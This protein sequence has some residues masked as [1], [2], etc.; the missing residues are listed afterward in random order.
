MTN[1]T[2]LFFLIPL[3]FLTR[4]E[5]RLQ[6]PSFSQTPWWVRRVGRGFS[7]RRPA[8][9][10]WGRKSGLWPGRLLCTASRLKGRN[11]G[12]E[13]Q[14]VQES[15]STFDTNKCAGERDGFD[16]KRSRTLTVSDLESIPEQCGG[17]GRVRL[18]E[19]FLI[20]L[21]R[22]GVMTGC[23]G[24]GAWSKSKAHP[25]TCKANSA[26]CQPIRTRSLW[27]PIGSFSRR[28]KWILIGYFSRI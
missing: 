19:N 5:T 21:G 17:S 14:E 1:W 24:I 26:G 8:K 3:S 4:G 9:S 7:V 11:P 12:E 28:R 25:F 20:L 10:G 18:L 2:R 13:K 6:Q 23:H 16:W 15:Y 27:S 22:P